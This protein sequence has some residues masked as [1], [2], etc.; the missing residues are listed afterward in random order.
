MEEKY[1]TLDN[2]ELISKFMNWMTIEEYS[3]YTAIKPG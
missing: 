3:P 1:L 2:I